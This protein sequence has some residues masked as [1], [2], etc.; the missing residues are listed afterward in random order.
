V[1][2]QRAGGGGRGGFDLRIVVRRAA[3]RAVGAELAAVGA[4]AQRQRALQQAR[5]LSRSLAWPDCF[6]RWLC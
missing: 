6:G 4:G 5:L 2:G 3:A 1:A